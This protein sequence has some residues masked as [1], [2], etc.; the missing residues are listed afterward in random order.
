MI[1]RMKKKRM[2]L[3]LL[4]LFVF[5]VVS[6]DPSGNVFLVNKYPFAIIAYIDFEYQ[7]ERLEKAVSLDVERIFALNARNFKYS[8][9]TRV[10]IETQDGQPLAE[11]S[12]EYILSIRNAYISKQKQIEAWI[13]TEKGL[14]LFNN[15][16][17]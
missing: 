10:C 11:Y 1:D 16:S 17:Y 2:A 4:S 7:G 14:E 12:S 5:E 9:I 15:F 3:V 6:C 13:I 8:Y